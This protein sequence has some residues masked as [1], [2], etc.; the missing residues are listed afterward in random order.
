MTMNTPRTK[1]PKDRAPST[2]TTHATPTQVAPEVAVKLP[3]DDTLDSIPRRVVTF[4]TAVGTS[5]EIRA[6]LS[7]RGYSDAVHQHGWQCLERVAG[8]SSLAPPPPRAGDTE[9]S[10]A[11]DAIAAWLTPNLAVADAA[12]STHHAPQHAFVFAG[13]L[14]PERGPSAVLVAQ[15]F[16]ARVDQLD[17][18]TRPGAVAGDRAAVE[19]LRARG[20][21]DVERARVRALLAQVQRGAAPDAASAGPIGVRRASP[22]GRALRGALYQWF[23]EWSR[24]A[25]AVITRRDQLIR[26]GLASRRT[27][28]KAA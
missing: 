21:T 25:R 10:D 11:G 1:T 23:H 2:E 9:T 3:S 6:K 19:T 14:K 27:A 18:G 16:L 17:A 15:T 5:P 13:D 24:I 26:L 7:E 22:D 12:L 8:R 28:K 20:I 4:L